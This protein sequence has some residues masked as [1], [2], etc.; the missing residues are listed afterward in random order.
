M[1]TPDP[2]STIATDSPQPSE[3][4]NSWSNQ[5]SE[6]KLAD[7]RKR[8]EIIER[9]DS[10][11]SRH[12]TISPEAKVRIVQGD[13]IV[14]GPLSWDWD[15]GHGVAGLIVTG[16]L[17]V[18]GP[19]INRNINNGPFLLVLERTCAQAIIGGGAELR[20]LGDAIVGEIVVGEYNDG[21][22]FF[23]GSLTVPV[24]IT[25]DH[26]FEV[27]GGVH[28]RWLD[29]FNE[30]HSWTSVV[31]PDLHVQKDEEGIEEF[32]VMAELVPRL[33]AGT[34]VLRPDLPPD[35]EFPELFE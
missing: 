27:A 5:G 23:G 17:T 19:I 2:Q 29:P 24:A 8:F 13:L 16:S 31:H 20:F 4:A 3:P 33:L 12:S 1:N 14:D 30:G 6:L 15:Q 25:N 35:E 26:H 32:D 22:L 9:L 34:P 21:I 10:V 7:A 28:G 11:S 18:R